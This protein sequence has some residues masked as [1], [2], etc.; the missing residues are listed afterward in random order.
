L[1]Q[2]VMERVGRVFLEA[3]F[4]GGTLNTTISRFVEAVTSGAY[5]LTGPGGVKPHQLLDACARSAVVRA[6]YLALID[7]SL[8]QLGDQARRGQDVGEV[9]SDVRS[10]E[11]AMILM[12]IVVGAQTLL[13]LKVPLEATR[14]AP[15]L[16]T[17]LR[18]APEK[19]K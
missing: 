5:P 13:E 1:L 2:T 8:A 18:R 10:T 9:R 11:L 3:L 16:L 15:A 14:L 19:I 12:C 17:L 4:S 6:R 7:Q